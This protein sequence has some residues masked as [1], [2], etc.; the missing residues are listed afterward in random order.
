MEKFFYAST[1]IFQIFR[2]QRRVCLQPGSDVGAGSVWK[3]DFYVRLNADT[4]VAASSLAN[5]GNYAYD[6]DI[7]NHDNLYRQ[8]I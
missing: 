4:Y 5:G 2:E 1:G 6:I 3:R 8:W 7:S